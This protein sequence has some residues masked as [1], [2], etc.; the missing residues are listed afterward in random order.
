MKILDHI[1][2][3][4]TTSSGLTVWSEGVLKLLK[5]LNP[6]KAACPDQ[7]PWRVLKELVSELAPAITSFSNSLST[8]QSCLT[9]AHSMDCS[10]Q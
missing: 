5:G 3:K 1:P 8:L 2:S 10:C 9:L 7:N 4:I 6:N